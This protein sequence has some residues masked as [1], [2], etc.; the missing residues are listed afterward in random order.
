MW[1]TMAHELA[2]QADDLPALVASLRAPLLILVGDQDKPFVIA[3][4]LMAEAF[5][6]AQFVVIPDAGH[7]PQYENPA[8]W[9]A[10]LTGFLSALPAT[11]R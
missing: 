7:S 3:S 9:I 10:A 11:A 4:E 5:P 2:H 8:A 6:S 1:G